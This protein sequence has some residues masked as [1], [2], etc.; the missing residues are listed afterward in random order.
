MRKILKNITEK[1]KVRMKVTKLKSM[2]K[3]MRTTQNI[4]ELKTNF[5]TMFQKKKQEEI[6]KI[7]YLRTFQKKQERS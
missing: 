4:K 7:E 5:P 3:I 6:W 2:R 1:K